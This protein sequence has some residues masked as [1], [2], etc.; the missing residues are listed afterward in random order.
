MQKTAEAGFVECEAAG[1]SKCT[2]QHYGGHAITASQEQR[3]EL[4]IIEPPSD[5]EGF[6][7]ALTYFI[8]AGLDFTFGDGDTLPHD[9]PDSLDG[10]K[11]V[12][13]LLEDLPRLQAQLGG[14][15]G[16]STTGDEPFASPNTHPIGVDIR[17]ALHENNHTWLVVFGNDA[18]LTK[19]QWLEYCAI[20]APDLTAPSQRFRDRM[21]AR[22]IRELYTATIERVLT[23]KQ[24]NRF[25]LPTG[26][27]YIGKALLEAA[28]ITGE[29]KYVDAFKTH[30]E[31]MLA[32]APEHYGGSVPLGTVNLMWMYELT[33][34]E[35]Y[36]QAVDK[37]AQPALDS[38]VFKPGAARWC[39]S[40]ETMTAETEQFVAQGEGMMGTYGEQMSIPL[41]LMRLARFTDRI[42]QY[43]DIAAQFVKSMHRNLADPDTG[44]YAH[45]VAARGLAGTMGH[46][47]GWSAV[48]LAQILDLFPKDHPQFDDLVRIYQS[49]CTAAMKVQ[50]PD[51][52]FHSILNWHFTPVN[53]HY[54]S[55]LTYALLHG[56]RKGYLDE[57]LREPALAGWKCLQGRLFRGCFVM[58]AAASGVSKRME[59]YLCKTSTI[60]IDMF[61]KDPGYAQE[62]LAFHEIM[63]LNNPE[64]DD[65]LP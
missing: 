59:Y 18:V 16:V 58:A 65:T 52:G 41:A 14:F 54:S 20:V 1:A 38:I 4:W 11:A 15:R 19:P 49:I 29:G 30:A 3:A 35:P 39:H 45:G 31:G 17:L 47:I 40:Q 21:A 48:G 23:C 37:L 26:R 36:R 7:R 22:P 2:A 63:F 55:W 6:R 43:S 44:L 62:L 28:K 61:D 51:G 32:R 42:E 46:G 9:M 5:F 34:Q 12:F 57:R 27:Y 64:L 8:N 56:V 25:D 53:E 33:G 13:V 60:R 10:I 24:M 50:G